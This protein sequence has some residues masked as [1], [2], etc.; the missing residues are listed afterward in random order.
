MLQGEQLA[1]FLSARVGKL[2]AS[3]M[4]VAMSFKKDGTPTAERSQLMRDLLA[5]RV[6]GESVRHYVTPAMKFGLDN[7]DSAKA[8]YEAH[9]G[10][11]LREAGVFDHPTIDM[12]AATPDALE[13]RD[14]LVETKVPTSPTFV[15]WVLAGVIPPEHV[16]QMAIQL[17]CTGRRYCNFV[18]FDPRQ[19]DPRRRL[20]IRRYEPTRE[21]LA[22]YE[23]AAVAFLDELETMFRAFTEAPMVA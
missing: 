23:K 4:R 5:E 20:F 19:K 22:T 10:I 1:E 17:S 13:D 21:E 9:T 3:R 14:G 11:L 8:A 18:A 6:T 16:P 7:E 2:T 15:A 12:L